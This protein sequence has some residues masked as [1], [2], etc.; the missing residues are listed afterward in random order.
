[1]DGYKN[2]TGK[3]ASY[4]KTMPSDSERILLASYNNLITFGK[5]FL[6]GDFGKS[7]TPF[8][9][10]E[11]GE[12]LLSDSN[13]PC[14][15]II[16][17]GHGKTQICMD[18]KILTDN[19]FKKMKDLN[20]GDTIFGSDGKSKNILG[21]SDIEMSDCYKVT[22]ADGREISVS[23]DHLFTVRD[24]C[25]QKGQEE[26]YHTL[27]TDYIYKTFKKKAG[28]YYR[29]RWAIDNALPIELPERKYNI[30]PY[31]IGLTIG[32]GSVTNPTGY[33]VI[34]GNIDDLM[35]YQENINENSKILGIRKNKTE[36][37]RQLSIYGIGPRMLENDM[38]YSCKDKKIPE[39]YKYGSIEQRKRL[40]MGLMDTDGTTF[41]GVTYYSTI[42]KRLAFDITN[43]V[44]SLGGNAKCTFR[45]NE[46]SGF[47][48][49]QIRTDFC[50]FML[51]RKID[52]WIN[53][54]RSF[55]T[56]IVNVEYVGKKFTRCLEVD[57]SDHLFVAG[58]YI[59]THN[60][61]IKA[62]ILHDLVFA[63]KAKEW[64]FTD[65]ERDLFFGWVSSSQKKSRNNIAYIKLNLEYNERINHYFSPKDKLS[66]R[67]DTWNA[68][69]LIT[70]YGDRLISSSNLTSMRGDTLATIK[71][72][73]V[74]YSRVFVDDAE[75]E[76]NTKT[77]N[78]RESLVD[79]IMNGILPAI[80]KNEPGCRLFLVETPV[81]WD[82]FAQ[83]ILDRWDKVQKEGQDAID[84]FSWK[85]IT[86]GATQ[87]NMP[88]GVLWDGWLSKEKLDEI[89]Q[90]Y[91]DSPRGVEGYFQEYELKV[92]SDENSL[93]TRKHIKYWDGYY[94]R[95]EGVNYLVIDGNLIPVNTF[96]GCDPAT[97][98][99]TKNSD[100]SVIQVV[101][102]DKSDNAYVIDY[103][104]HRS[105][106]TLG[107]RD[108]DGEI[109][110]KPGVVDHI[111]RLYDKYNC[112]MGVVE[113]VAMTRSVFQSLNAE[114]KRLNRW[115][116]NIVPEKPGGE[117]KIN[118]I[119]SGLNGR[120]SAGKIFLRENQ[121]DL[122]NE[123]IKFGPKMSHDD[124]IE[125]LYYALK[126][127]YP[128]SNLSSKP[129][130][131]TGLYRK[132]TKRKPKAW[133]IA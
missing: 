106:P 108:A 27:R 92:Q 4:I 61:L 130:M 17:R 62:A 16:S 60:T 78:S 85:V 89:K 104:R 109:D 12:E 100:Y 47:Y 98:I 26:N 44:R 72:G 123:I 81:H 80:E 46:Y 5:I 86:Y 82:S 15:I 71:S 112:S 6:R 91:Q 116:I 73:A 131:E 132:H 53:P 110:G 30:D 97:D 68:E 83:Q 117:H 79:N 90:M 31:L 38:R 65:K 41:D 54:K 39:H 19:G 2:Y 1:M 7:K 23:D 58:D 10:Y 87:P 66:L 67:G 40:L 115:D 105:I 3:S 9:H 63:K 52:K 20:I 99:E 128:P 42:S 29:N 96:I 21:F 107:L 11:I 57:S 120:F 13:K 51:K 43:L 122:I 18:E 118:R 75:N 49:I 50:P 102:V 74:R 133:I 14:A 125:A 35:F 121:F 59:L 48:D 55:Y 124:T 70:A 22:M 103:E 77:Q 32:D 36:W 93:W 126:R 37:N 33:T 64:G 45:E 113:D 28:K 76:G 24:Q 34:H 119:Y 25:P 111:I 101:A 56:S 95:I 94:S 127:A 114:R 8:F 129:E 88:G 84:Q 69:D